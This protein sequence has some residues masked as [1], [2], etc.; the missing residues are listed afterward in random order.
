MLM[1]ARLTLFVSLIAAS[2]SWAT[3]A[4]AERRVALVIGNSQYQHAATLR[5]PRNDATEMAGTLRKLGFDVDVVLDLDQQSFARTIDMFA[6][7]LDGADVALFFF[8]GHG[9]Q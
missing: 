8:A 4:Q 3:H 2:L 6:R 7:K 9:L 5:N 1:L